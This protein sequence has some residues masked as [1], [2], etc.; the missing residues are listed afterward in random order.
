MHQPNNNRRDAV[1]R[2][3]AGGWTIPARAQ[4]RK[5]PEG[6]LVGPLPA[7]SELRGLYTDYLR[8]QECGGTN[9]RSMLAVMGYCLKAIH[10]L[11]DEVLRLRTDAHEEA[12]K[13]L[14]A[15][16]ELV[17]EALDALTN[18]AAILDVIEKAKTKA[19]KSRSAQTNQ[20]KTTSKAVAAAKAV[21][22]QR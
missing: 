9:D 3:I 1:I 18:T 20:K 6:A 2:P 22:E 4:L 14:R 5:R 13:E 21:G 10:Q 19:N 15:E 17:V 16:L 11:E 8:A 7:G 12:I